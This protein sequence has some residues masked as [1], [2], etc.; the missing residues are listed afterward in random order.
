VWGKYL[1]RQNIGGDRALVSIAAELVGCCAPV[2]LDSRRNFDLMFGIGDLLLGILLGCDRI[3]LIDGLIAF[4]ES[5]SG[6]Q[7]T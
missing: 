7:K 3:V 6:C 2:K 5:Y 1:L 4:F